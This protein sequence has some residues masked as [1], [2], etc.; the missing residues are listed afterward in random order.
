[1]IELRG[2]LDEYLTLRR[3]LGYK[4]ERSGKVLADFVDFLDGTGATHISVEAAVAWAIQAP[5]AE[6]S[7]RAG[8][9]GMVRGFARYLQAIDPRHQVPPTGLIPR[10]RGRP[11]PYLFSEAD[12]VAVMA[13]AG[14]LRSPLRRSTIE[15]VIGTLAVT[16]LRVGEVLRLDRGDLDVNASV[17]AVRNSKGG[18]SR[19]VPLAPT[20]LAALVAY[21]AQ[22][23]G[24]FPHAESLFVSTTGSRLRP[25]N[26][27]TVFGELASR[28]GLEPRAGGKQPRLG[29]LRHNFAVRTLLGFY[30]S[31]ADVA[32][33]LPV[34]STYLGHVSPASTYWYLSAAP[35]L[36][37]VAAQRVEA[38]R[39]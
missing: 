1:M 28:A 5:G 26:L 13:A 22:R 37:A 36:L 31:G 30:T 34:L 14:E 23:D 19:H 38:G 20:T 17:L 7:W 16:G 10:R 12:I 18:K 6:S 2:S 35:E 11:T 33:M 3:S 32:A 4:L 24:L 27:G 25:G 9:L 8:R 21:R 15:T 39:R 29:G